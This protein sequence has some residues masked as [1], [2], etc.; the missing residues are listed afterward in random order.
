MKFN[1]HSELEG[2]H[3]FLSPSSYHWLNYDDDKLIFRYQS[4]SA[5]ERGTRLHSLA[6]ECISLGV[7]LRGTGTLASFVNDAINYRLI[8]EQSLYFSKYCFGTADAIGF[9]RMWLRIHDLKTGETPAKMEQLWIYAALFCL[10]YGFL[11]G[12]IGI[13]TRIYQNDEIVVD[14]PDAT[15]IVP[16]MDK[17]RYFDRL[18]RSL[19]D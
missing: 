18:L 19:D 14:N 6:A 11:P 4:V 2:K 1:A 9:S 12:E 7:R 15:V 10:E 3:A 16:I 13:E 5:K 8:P 17:I